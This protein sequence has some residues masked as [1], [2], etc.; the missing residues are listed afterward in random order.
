LIEVTPR[1]G[2]LGGDAPPTPDAGRLGPNST[3]QNPRRRFRSG[4]EVA[5]EEIGRR[6]GVGI[7]EE[8]PFGG[9]ALGSSVAGV[10]GRLDLGARYDRDP[11]LLRGLPWTD[12]IAVVHD[13][14][15]VAPGE[16]KTAK[17]S[18][19]LRERLLRAQERHHDIHPGPTRWR[20]IAVQA[21]RGFDDD[22]SSRPA[23][24]TEPVATDP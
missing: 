14:Q 12:A 23:A 1:V 11:L 15:R 6:V 16:M 8:D 13:H 9:P 24:L 20:A 5:V 3:R 10:V 22:G 17:P 4:L 7:E 2:V 21:S 18:D 19:D